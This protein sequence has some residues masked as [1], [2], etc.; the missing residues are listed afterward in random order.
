MP[1]INNNNNNNVSESD[2]VLSSL[3]RKQLAVYGRLKQPK[4][5]NCIMIG[6]VEYRI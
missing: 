2:S 3:R 4:S 5:T 6:L 1:G